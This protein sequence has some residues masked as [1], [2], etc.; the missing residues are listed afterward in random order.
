MTIIETQADM[1][2]HSWDLDGDYGNVSSPK[3]QGENRM[4]IESAILKN[5]KSCLNR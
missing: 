2:Q 1:K 3:A 5:V 4:M